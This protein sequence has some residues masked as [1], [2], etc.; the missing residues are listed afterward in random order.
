[1]DLVA[2]YKQPQDVE[3]SLPWTI[4]STAMLIRQQVGAGA[5][6]APS[7]LYLSNRPMNPPETLTWLS[8]A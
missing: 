8:M 4:I 7:D 6:E 2:K 5:A 3:S 1:M